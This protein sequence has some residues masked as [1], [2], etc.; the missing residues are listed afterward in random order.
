MLLHCS[1]PCDPQEST[2][3]STLC[4]CLA[5]TI[6]CHSADHD[7]SLEASG[8]TSVTT[9]DRLHAREW[10]RLVSVLTELSFLQGSTC[11]MIRDH[12]NVFAISMAISSCTSENSLF[13]QQAQ[14]AQCGITHEFLAI[15]D[16]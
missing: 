14:E 9:G 16:H 1:P 10:R 2:E 5:E 6:S 8:N 4:G 15:C 3:Y 13:L 7:I 11:I 12:I